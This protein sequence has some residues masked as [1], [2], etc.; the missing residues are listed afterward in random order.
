MEDKVGYRKKYAIVVIGLFLVML[1]LGGCSRKTDSELRFEME[2]L[3]TQ[4][5][6]DLEQAKTNSPKMETVDIEKFLVAYSNIAK[7]IKL[8]KQVKDVERSNDNR[9]QLWALASLATTRVGNLYIESKQYDKAFESFKVVVDCPA[10]TPLQR[11][12]LYGFMAM[13]KELSRAFPDA[14]QYYDSL[15]IGYLELIVPQSPNMDAMNAPL[16][17][18]EMWADAGNESNYK[19]RLIKA[20]DYYRGIMNKYNSTLV[21]AA[22]AGKLA[23]S[24]LQQNSFTEAI[25][26]LETVKDTTGYTAPNIML[27]IADIYLNR[28]QDNQS[29]EK[30]YREF[31]TI[32]PKSKDFATAKFGL[33]LSL[34]AQKRYAEARKAVDGMEKISGAT[35]RDV[36]QAIYLTALCF[37]S[38]DK[39]ELAKGKYDFVQV[40]YPGTEQAYEAA[41]HIPNYFRNKGQTDLARRAY[42]SS[43][44]YISKLADQNKADE[45]AAAKALGYLVRAYLDNNDNSKAAELLEQLHTK[46]PKLPEGKLAPLRLAD[47]Y[48]NSSHDTLK[49]IE[50]LKTF[51][52]ENPN[53]TDHD[54]IQSHLNLLQSKTGTKQ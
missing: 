12:A 5:D 23:A 19:S 7:M 24:F 31:E 53:S 43:V 29:A 32:Y 11:N 47:I 38:E 48:E 41:L 10:T 51:L 42:E 4:A 1:I 33:G 9:R 50:W 44:A 18:A 40:S 52:A 36:A 13:A 46:Y 27:M 35:E 49:T 6:H 21:G 22:A 28:M 25:A 2:K 26:V 34:F 30:T 17:S 37:E 45:T 3:L 20:Q 15:A 16:K 54:K 39:W 14:A 8:P